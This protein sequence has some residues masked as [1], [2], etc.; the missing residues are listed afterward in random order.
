[1]I[2]RAVLLLGITG[3]MLAASTG[4]IATN[5]PA[6]GATTGRVPVLFIHGFTM[7]NTAMW[8]V[9]KPIFL[10]DGYRSGD[11]TEYN[12]NSTYEGAEASA[13]KLAPVVERLA[14]QSPNGKVDI[15]AHSEGNLVLQT[16][17]FFYGCKNKIDHWVNLAG[18]QNGTMLASAVI[19]G[20]GGAADMNPLSLLVGRLNAAE[21]REIPAQ[22]V[23]S[24]IFY[25]L[26]DG[27][28]IPGDLC[29]EKWAKNVPFIGT[30]LTVYA[31]PIVIKQGLDFIKGR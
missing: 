21:A 25:T 28:I 5:R 7:Q 20:G 15:V 9:A 27:V 30:H 8:T 17:M 4:C 16:C 26:T 12:Y 10:A 31:D 6:V 23:N 18:A 11:L 19:V 14:A 2:R 3:S 29:K 22:N 24:I 1:M 13:R